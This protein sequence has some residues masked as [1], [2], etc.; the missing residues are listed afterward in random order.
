[1]FAVIVFVPVL[2]QVSAGLSPTTAGLLLATMTIG[3]TGATTLA[4]RRITRSGR[5]RRLPVLGASV[6]AAALAGLAF[7]APAASPVVVVA[8]LLVFDAG[9]GLTSQLLVVAVRNGVERT[10]IGVATSTTAF[11]RAFGGASGAAGRPVA[12]AVQTTMFVAAAIA[13]IAALV[14]VALPADVDRDASAS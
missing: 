14:M 9:F 2:L 13:A 6:M 7:A 3:M 12:D 11:F 8:G 4:G 5:L 10:R 1:L